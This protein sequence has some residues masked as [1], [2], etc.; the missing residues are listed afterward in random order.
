MGIG[1]PAVGRGRTEF[2]VGLPGLSRQHARSGLFVCPFLHQ[3][4]ARLEIRREEDKKSYG[5]E[6]I[7][8]IGQ[9]CNMTIW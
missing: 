7:H 1:R 5:E 9:I 4:T 6:R 3:R 8:L 2:Y